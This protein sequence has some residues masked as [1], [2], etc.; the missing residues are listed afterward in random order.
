[1]ATSLNTPKKTKPPQE[2]ASSG[3]PG[4]SGLCALLPPMPTTSPGEGME[5]FPTWSIR[6]AIKPQYS[7]TPGKNAGELDI[8]QASKSFERIIL[9]SIH[10]VASAPSNK[11]KRRK[12]DVGVVVIIDEHYLQKITDTNKPPVKSKKTRASTS[13]ESSVAPYT[14][15][16]EH[17]VLSKMVQKPLSG[18]DELQKCWKWLSP[19]TE[20]KNLVGCWCVCLYETVKKKDKLSVGCILK[21]FLMGKNSPMESLEINFS[22][23]DHTGSAGEGLYENVS[24]FLPPY[25]DVFEASNII[26]KAEMVPL[27]GEKWKMNNFNEVKNLAFAVTRQERRRLSVEFV[28]K[29]AI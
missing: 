14:S 3:V 1:M 5:W 4:C 2:E 27:K 18:N 20:E 25:I 16:I 7:S 23:R 21:R 24:E 15:S 8:S 22:L 10:P 12:I 19:P 13:V 11:T 26:A 6:P 29:F 9:D 17:T 28:A